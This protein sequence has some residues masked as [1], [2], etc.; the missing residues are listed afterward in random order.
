MAVS[1]K[2]FPPNVTVVGLPLLTV[3]LGGDGDVAA[4]VISPATVTDPTRFDFDWLGPFEARKGFIGEVV[5]S[6]AEEEEKAAVEATALTSRFT[7][8]AAADASAS[9]SVFIIALRRKETRE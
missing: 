1:S 5:K 9:A 4:D 6:G 3:L 7:V 2:S 8:A